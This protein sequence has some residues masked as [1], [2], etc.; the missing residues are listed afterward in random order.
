M[1][2]LKTATSRHD[3]REAVAADSTRSFLSAHPDVPVP[4]VERA[5]G[6]PAG[7]PPVPSPHQVWWDRLPADGRSH[8]SACVEADDVDPQ[9]LAIL[10]C[11]GP[12]G[13][14]GVRWAGGS[15]T[16]LPGSFVDFVRTRAADQHDDTPVED[17]PSGAGPVT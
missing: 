5:A 6:A 12:V 10:R 13:P 17:A 8:T 9:M 11:S 15:A 1:S 4:P 2:Q 14:F 7:T 3:A 16:F